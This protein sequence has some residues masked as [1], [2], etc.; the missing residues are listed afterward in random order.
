MLLK[1]TL[2]SQRFSRR[3][4]WTVRFQGKLRDLAGMGTK[5]EIK[6]LD[7]IES[8]S[9]RTGRTPLGVAW[10]AAQLQLELIRAVK[11]VKAAEV[12]G[13]LRRMKDTVGDIDLSLI[14]I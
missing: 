12:A 2:V 9:R 7:G 3:P 5:S 10:P 11:G 14:H 13:S 8:L 6:I 4:R 1:L